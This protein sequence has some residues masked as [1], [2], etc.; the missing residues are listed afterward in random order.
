M[1]VRQDVGG[2]RTGLGQEGGVCF[3]GP[4]D[5]LSKITAGA[6]GFDRRRRGHP[7]RRV[8]VLG[9]QSGH[10][11]A[12]ELGKARGRDEK[13]KGQVGILKLARREI[14]KLH[15]PQRRLD[16][17]LFLVRG[18]PAHSLQT[19][20]VWRPGRSME[21]RRQYFVVAIGRRP[22]QG[23]GPLPLPGRPSRN[24][25]LSRRSLSYKKG[26]GGVFE[27]VLRPGIEIGRLDEEDDRRSHLPGQRTDLLVQPAEL[28]KPLGGEAPD[29]E[30][31]VPGIDGQ[32][33]LP[34]CGQADHVTGILL[35]PALKQGVVLGVPGKLSIFI[36]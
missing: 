7:E 21:E 29:Q 15:V 14:K 17:L 33:D 18:Q 25:P 35:G 23:H 19:K 9:G 10:P 4:G 12:L 28:L 1:G 22:G 27:L 20:A 16:D 30:F 36:I 31:Q 26:P 34:L 13:R 3:V 8:V 5:E 2:G 24:S 11:V 6:D 32:A